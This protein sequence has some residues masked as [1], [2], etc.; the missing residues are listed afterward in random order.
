MHDNFVTTV[1]LRAYG[2]RQ[3][4]SGDSR[5][6]AT[7]ARE[8]SA[9][10]AYANRNVVRHSIIFDL[11]QPSLYFLSTSLPERAD[12][13]SLASI[14]KLANHMGFAPLRIDELL[15]NSVRGVDCPRYRAGG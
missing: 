1:Q 6:H 13:K 7:A 8:Y 11:R 14:C 5:G 12:V 2:C 3:Q 10:M 4:D 9:K 15:L